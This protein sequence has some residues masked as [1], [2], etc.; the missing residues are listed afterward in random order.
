MTC[1]NEGRRSSLKEKQDNF[2]AVVRKREMLALRPPRLKKKGKQT[3]QTYDISFVK[4]VTRK[5]HVLVGQNN[6]KEMY[7]KACC[8]FANETF[9]W[10][11]FSLPS[12]V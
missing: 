2:I 4:R 8:F 10:G 5:F 11:Q 3:L 9:F 1:K 6:G 12:A 7:K